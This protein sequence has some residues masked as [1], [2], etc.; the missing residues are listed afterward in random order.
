MWRLFLERLSAESDAVA[1]LEG[2][3]Q[4]SVKELSQ[5]VLL[6]S[7]ELKTWRSNVGLYFEKT[8]IA[9]I[10][11]LLT[12]L[13]LQ[14]CYVPLDASFSERVAHLISLASIY[15]VL[16]GGEI[17][18]SQVPV[19]D[20]TQVMKRELL[21]SSTEEL[22]EVSSER[23]LYVIFTSG[24]TGRPKGV[25]GLESATMNRLRWQWRVFPFRNEVTLAR[26]PLIF[27]D[28]VAE[29]FGS[30]L[31]PGS[32][33]ACLTGEGRDALSYAVHALPRLLDCCHKA[34]V[35][36]LVMTPTL[37]NACLLEAENVGLDC[38]ASL[39]L[40]TCSGEPLKR[41]LAQKLY[42]KL[43]NCKILNIYGS[44]EVAGDATCAVLPMDDTGS[45]PLVA[46]GESIDAVEVEI[47][48][49]GE[50]CGMGEEGE[51]MIFGACLSPGY[52]EDEESTR[53]AFA[54]I[55]GRRGF[56]SFDLASW[57][58]SK[59]RK[60]TLLILGRCNQL[61]KVRGQRVELS[62]VESVLCSADLATAAGL[63]E[64]PIFTEAC[65]LVHEVAGH[66][67]L[68][69]AVSPQC[70]LEEQML[71][72]CLSKLLPPAAVPS[73]LLLL[74]QL[75]RLASGKV[76]RRRLLEPFKG[77]AVCGGDDL[78]RLVRQAWQDC[79]PC[80]C[81]DDQLSF[82]ASGGDSAGLLTLA[83]R[84]RRALDVAFDAVLQAE[85]LT[86]LLA[87]CRAAPRRRSRS[88]RHQRG[89]E[90]KASSSYTWALAWRKDLGQCVDARALLVSQPPALY[91]PLGKRRALRAFF[92]L[93]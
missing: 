4:R 21:R 39:R 40:L 55:S 81:H 43:P 17:A 2:T 92:G 13:R 68:V 76:D 42:E 46:C 77:G 5:H 56:R 24:S 70:G 48:R 85:S 62:F 75:P 23:R 12:V 37:L 41:D 51:V 87:L 50:L 54:T 73:S 89:Q 15:G 22:R 3:E 60:R 52:F 78:E 53:A 57:Q 61:V 69:A 18:L 14:L 84:L 88:P 30:L 7:E 82:Q 31:V 64:S 59:A 19:L 67:A 83:A 34:R 80:A 26:T 1:V 27:V 11:S 58:L 25:V 44:T 10:V 90:P 86:A 38:W 45:H 66:V 49:D 72:Q 79:L 32:R 65:C 63:G 6:L 71:R 93:P 91:L 8:S 35:T 36:R 33:L 28:H 20:V 29:L 47:R 9:T 74:P 16:S